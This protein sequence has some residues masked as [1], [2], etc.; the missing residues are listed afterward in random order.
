M[1]HFALPSD[2]LYKARMEGRLHR[3]FMG[4]TTQN[5][6]LLLGLGVSAISDTGHA[7]AQNNKTLH[8]YYAAVSSGE[9]AV[10]KGY[11]LNDTDI[12]FKKYILDI[13][14][15]GQTIFHAEDLPLLEEFAFPQL[16][17]LQSD[18][19]IDW[20]YTGLQIT[21]QGHYFIRNICSAFDLYL[22]HAV[23]GKQLFS[24]AI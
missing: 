20:D 12:A 13:A 8:D 6:G 17:E 18:G 22:H 9:L 23:A 24:K 10:Q 21:A 15:K 11:I 19:L 7:F 5:S 3:N 4:Y 1:D 16:A 2:E 14:C